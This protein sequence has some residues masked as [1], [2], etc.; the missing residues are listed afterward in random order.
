MFDFFPSQRKE[1][2]IGVEARRTHLLREL[3]LFQQDKQD[4]FSNR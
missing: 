3:E 1:A 2:H 4:F